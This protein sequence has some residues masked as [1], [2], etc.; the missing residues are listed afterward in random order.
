MTCPEQAD[1]DEECDTDKC[2]VCEV[3]AG[4]QRCLK[5]E[6][7]YVIH[8][9]DNSDGDYEEKCIVQSG[10]TLNCNRTDHNSQVDC[11]ECELNYYMHYGKCTKNE[12]L[13]YAYN[14]SEK[15]STMIHKIL[16]AILVV[17]V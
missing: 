9:Y 5:C 2:Q 10:N 3:M 16:T 7:G 4:W 11:L 13:D 12:N 6:A 8:S 1:S 14:L 15:S 17:L